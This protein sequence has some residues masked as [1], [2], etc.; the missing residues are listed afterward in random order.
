MS[1]PFGLIFKF[2]RHPNT[3]YSPETAFP[4]GIPGGREEGEGIGRYD[5]GTT[6]EWIQ[7]C[8][9][10]LVVSLSLSLPLLS[11]SLSPL[12]SSLDRQ[13]P[14]QELGIQHRLISRNAPALA[15][16]CTHESDPRVR[17][18]VFTVDDYPSLLALPK[19]R[20]DDRGN[21]GIRFLTHTHA[22]AYILRF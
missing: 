14:H 4:S 11:P 8:G 7:S 6:G 22:R 12:L 2:S 21:S 9:L 1:L 3:S 10:K 15:F 5:P 18:D 19:G 17:V 13:R 16:T 20:N